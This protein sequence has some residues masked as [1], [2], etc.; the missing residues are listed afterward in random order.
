[1]GRPPHVRVR[2]KGDPLDHPHLSHDDAKDRH[3]NEIQNHHL[4]LGGFHDGRSAQNLAR[5][6]ARNGDQSNDGHGIEHGRRRGSHGLGHESSTGFGGGRAQTEQDFHFQGLF[7]ETA[8]E[9]GQ[10]QGRS[11]NDIA[12]NHADNGN[13]V[14]WI[15][16]RLR[17]EDNAETKES[18]DR[19]GETDTGQ[20]G[21]KNAVKMIFGPMDGF[22]TGQDNHAHDIEYNIIRSLLRKEPLENGAEN[23]QLNDGPNRSH[24]N[25]SFQLKM[26]ESR[27]P[28]DTDQGNDAQC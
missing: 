28:C 12:Q 3:G 5:H 14:L 4:V 22:P 8:G 25:G 19:N 23:G 10:R 20:D 16:E 26:T 17:L 21:S 7:H 18:H 11:G 27:D 15:P 24:G 1:M 2:I 6:H 13:G 9:C